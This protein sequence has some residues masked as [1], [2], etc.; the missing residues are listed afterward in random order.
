MKKKIYKT[1]T[2]GVAMVFSVASIV[3]GTK[4]LFGISQPD[5]IVFTPLLVY[6]VIMG[7]IG[8]LGGVIIWMNH[9]RALTLVT[10]I[11]VVHFFVLLLIVA[12]YLLSGTVALDSVQAMIL[13]S[14][15]WG[16]IAVITWK[17]NK[18]DK[19]YVGKYDPI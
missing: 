11:A 19:I 2:A 5:Y 18:S 14:L 15:I 10:T 12:V 9:R 7:V 13:R 3:E 8:V 4:V 16:F 17:N 6:N 1:I